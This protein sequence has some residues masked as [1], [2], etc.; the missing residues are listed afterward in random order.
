MYDELTHVPENQLV[1]IG[2][3]QDVIDALARLAEESVTWVKPTE[4][5]FLVGGEKLLPELQGVLRRMDPHLVKWVDKKPEKIR[6]TGQAP[7]EGFKLETNVIIDVDRTLF[8]VSLAPTSIRRQLSP[9][10]RF[11]EGLGLRPEEVIT[12]IRTRPER[13]SRGKYTVCVFE[14]VRTLDSSQHEKE[15]RVDGDII[16]MTAPTST[17]ACHEE[18]NPWA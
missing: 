15:A 8:G 14:Y 18:Q 1:E 13:S 4:G 6:F 11:L 16:D 17:Q 9:Y 3:P 7:P 12:R 10:L 2:I 5:G